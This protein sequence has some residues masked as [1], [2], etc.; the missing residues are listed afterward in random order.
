MLELQMLAIMHARS[1][2]LSH[3]KL[4]TNWKFLSHQK[5]ILYHQA[6][7][8][9]IFQKDLQYAWSAEDQEIQHRKFIGLE[10]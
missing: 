2:H 5:S 1:V 8:A 4:C 9:W 10:R 6:V 3:R 7:V